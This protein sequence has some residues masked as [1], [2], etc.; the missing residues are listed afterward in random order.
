MPYRQSISTQKIPAENYNIL[1]SLQIHSTFHHKLK[2][3]QS[4]PKRCPFWQEAK[5]KSHRFKS[6]SL[7]CCHTFPHYQ[8]HWSR[9]CPQKRR[10]ICRL[11]LSKRRKHVIRTLLQH[12]PI[13]YPSL[14][15]FRTML[16]SKGSRWEDLDEQNRQRRINVRSSIN[17][18]VHIS[19]LK[20]TIL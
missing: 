7:Q 10:Y 6:T 4:Q 17:F 5:V 12:A 13:C 16:M 15:A 1:P 3:L 8:G 14:S 11:R 9:A 19:S 2:W 20:E 18:N